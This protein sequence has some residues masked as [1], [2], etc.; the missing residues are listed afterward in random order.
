[1]VRSGGGRGRSLKFENSVSAAAEENIQ[2]RIF[3]SVK[4]MLLISVII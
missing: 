4:D 2:H 1:M 3:D